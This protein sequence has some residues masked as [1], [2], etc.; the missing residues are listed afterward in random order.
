MAVAL[1][2]AAMGMMPTLHAQGLQEPDVIDTIIGAE[3][4]EEEMEAAADIDRVIKAIELT[5]NNISMVRKTTV[6]DKVD[7][8]FLTDSTA[9]EGGPPA[10]IAKK[11]E[12]YKVEI[13]QL[14]QELESN[15]MLFHAIDSR[16]IL[17]ADVLA[18]EFDNHDVL[19]YSAG[20]STN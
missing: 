7:I 4:Q 10:A 2:L 19:V 15:A 9:A 13:V 11:L 5:A 8:I 18:V 12:E 14:R 3:V 17:P 16:Q 6:L 1:T 20:K